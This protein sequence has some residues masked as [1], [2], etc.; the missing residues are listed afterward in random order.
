MET[1]L[2]TT[3]HKIGGRGKMMVITSSR[4]AAVRNYHEVKRCIEEQSYNDIGVLVV[5]SGSV[6]DGEEE[7]TEPKLITRPDGSHIRE[8]QTKAE[9]RENFHVLIVAEK[10][11]TGFD[12]PLL[13]TILVDKKL[14]GVKAV[15]T[16]SRLN[17]TCPG[18][19]DTFVLDFINSAEDI[20]VAFDPVYQETILEREINTDLLYEVQKKLRGYPVYTDTDIEA[21][22]GEYFRKDR[23]DKNTMGRMT[24]VLTPVKERYNKLSP[25]SRY[26]FRRLCRSLAKRYGYISQVVS[27]FDADLHKEY[28]VVTCDTHSYGGAATTLRYAEQ[29]HK[30]II[31]LVE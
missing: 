26:Q 24:S 19:N 17:R 29:K 5:F 27:M 9:F 28:V 10:Y 20:K 25:D 31:R 30:R 14:R 13:H 15:Q 22:C 3:R 21:F 12:E 23:Q 11:Q 7:F 8:A 4:L 16:L 18:K 2:G 1:F 6:K